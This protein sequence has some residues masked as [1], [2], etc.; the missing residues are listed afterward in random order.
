[1]RAQFETAVILQPARSALVLRV[2]ASIMVLV[3]AALFANSASGPSG[4]GFVR[5][6]DSRAERCDSAAS[7]IEGRRV[8]IDSEPFRVNSPSASGCTA[9][10]SFFVVARPMRLEL[11][12]DANAPSSVAIDGRLIATL[13][14]ATRTTRTVELDLARGVHPFVVAFSNENENGYLRI[15]AQ[16]RRGQWMAGPTPLERERFF[17]T[18]RA[19]DAYLADGAPTS[20]STS[21]ALWAF[22]ALSAACACLWV[23][24]NIARS[25]DV[26]HTRNIFAESAFA[27]ACFA[28]T[29]L[30]RV[31]AQR[32]QDL[33][34][35]ELW[36]S[37]AAEHYIRNALLGDFTAEAYR[38]NHEH[39][40][41]AKW[42]YSLGAFF[43]GLDGARAIGFILSAWTVVFVY[44]T[45][46][47]FESRRVALTSALT[48]S[49]MPHVAA[50]ARIVGHETIQLFFWS[51]TLL[52]VCT[53]MRFGAGHSRSRASMYAFLI[54]LLPV[55]GTFS[56]FTFIWFAPVIL[57]AWWLATSRVRWTAW[58]SVPWSTIVGVV[59]GCVLVFALWPWLHEDG[60]A[61]WAET[62]SHWDRICSGH[63][64]GVFYNGLPASF[65]AVMFT[66]TTPVALLIAAAGGIVVGFVR[67]RRAALLMLVAFL[68]PFL[69][70]ILHGR[71]DLA[72]YVCP[73]WIGVSIF[74]A[75]GADAACAFIGAKVSA[76]RP[77][78]KHTLAALPCAALCIYTFASLKRVEPY[79]LDYYSEIT[80]GVS[81]VFRKQTGELAWWAEG[82]G[83]AGAWIN[84]HARRGARVRIDTN[85]EGVRPRLRDDLIEVAQHSNLPADYVMTNLYRYQESVPRGCQRVYEAGLDGVRFATVWSCTAN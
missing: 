23:A 25:N 77:M 65:Y 30:D 46:R 74:A 76:M 70:S 1:M 18:Q 40:P 73:A 12:L 6:V 10:R 31:V 48:L 41:I 35:D 21:K 50:H 38:W 8:G 45:V 57:V 47:T 52:A 49:F 24:R 71:Q 59:V 39:P 85:S 29:L 13:S 44:A 37:N 3:C 83:H 66:L 11:R 4:A 64:L 80:G 19:A 2:A 5:T 17:T 62:S 42:I 20:R 81:E 53:W 33:G 61:H 78:W 69:H 68:A 67:N 7:V 54:G 27:V 15:F 60:K 63:Y 43:S 14:A 9:W 79:P 72:R 28:T 75:W 84:E 82:I 26:T 58:L 16:D 36:Y 22:L 32:W 56:R 51:A 34:W 55:L